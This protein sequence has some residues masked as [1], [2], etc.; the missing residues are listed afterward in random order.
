[1]TGNSCQD[2]AEK[3][4]D[5][6]VQGYITKPID[7]ENLIFRIKRLLGME[8]FEVLR[9]Q[10]GPD[11]ETRIAAISPTIKKALYYIG[12]NY[13]QDL[14]RNKVAGYL[15]ISPDYLSRQFHKECELHLMEYLNQ[16]RMHKS[17]QLLRDGNRKIKDVAASVGITDDKY[18]S[19]VFKK[20]S[21]ITPKG[22][23]KRLLS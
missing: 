20:H 4:A 17:R 6:N 5:L 14:T 8:D 21:S 19:K 3:C 13:Q 16:V 7:V 18:F 1:M 23:R 22:F 15:N 2:W 9:E 11:Y 12:L 10:W